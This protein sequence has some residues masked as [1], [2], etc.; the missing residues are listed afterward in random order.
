MRC[1]Q[2]R[3]ELDE[4]EL[5]SCPETD[6]RVELLANELEEGARADWEQK[7]K[8][9]AQLY[10]RARQQSPGSHANK[11]RRTT[12][13]QRQLL[14]VSYTLSSAPSSRAICRGCKQH[15]KR[16]RLRLEH[17]AGYLHA[18]CHDYQRDLDAACAVRVG[19]RASSELTVTM[20]ANVQHPAHGVRL[21][22]RA[23]WK[24]DIESLKESLRATGGNCPWWLRVE[25]RGNIF[26]DEREEIEDGSDP[27][28]RAIDDSLNHSAELFE[29]GDVAA[30]VAECGGAVERLRSALGATNQHTLRAQLLLANLVAKHGRLAESVAMYGEVIDQFKQQLGENDLETLGAQVD[31]A[32]VLMQ[33][34]RLHEAR[35]IMSDVVREYDSQLGQFH[36]DTMEARHWLAN[37]LHEQGQLQAAL[38]IYETLLEQRRHIDGEHAQE[39]LGVRMCLANVLMQQGKL[40]EALALHEGVV[41][42]L[43]EMVGPHHPDTYSAQNNL[44]TVSIVCKVA[45]SHRIVSMLAP[46]IHHVSCQSIN[47]FCMSCI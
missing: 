44:A 26:A 17:S 34:D 3:G 9:G 32:N 7:K 15:I 31:C 13:E 25:M 35:I 47:C 5:C 46:D 1:P 43:M 16:G 27:Q 12:G 39:T 30:A 36:E 8:D 33:M 21:K 28:L 6:A 11:Q 10:T 40:E 20:I 38:T 23:E 37:L 22:E 24:R 41:G 42:K 4:Q 19:A 45:A 18:G 29:S 14:T 2:C